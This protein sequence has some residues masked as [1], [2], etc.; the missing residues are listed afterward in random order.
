MAGLTS[1][2]RARYA[3]QQ[4]RHGDHTMVLLGRQSKAIPARQAPVPSRLC[5]LG[6]ADTMGAT[7]WLLLHFGI[8][9][10]ALDIPAAF[11]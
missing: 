5:F 11:P 7:G 2:C 9:R 10:K 6:W 1:A 3:K 8:M 4:P